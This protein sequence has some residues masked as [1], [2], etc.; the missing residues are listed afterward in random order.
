LTGVFATKANPAGDGFGRELRADGR[1]VTRFS[2]HRH[3]GG[4]DGV[5]S[6]LLRVTIGVKADVREQLSGLDLG[7]GRRYFG[8]GG[9]LPG[10]VARRRVIVSTAP[11]AGGKKSAALAS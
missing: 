1:C 7:R 9:P 10:R 5:F 11:A 8:D 6:A 2:R 3:F 4:R